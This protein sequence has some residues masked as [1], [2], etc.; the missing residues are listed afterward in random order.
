MWVG[1]V[2]RRGRRKVELVYFATFFV[3]ISRVKRCKARSVLG[4]I[5]L[6]R[7]VLLL[8][9]LYPLSKRNRLI[10]ARNFICVVVETVYDLE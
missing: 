3:Q 7:A 8:C 2:N 4:L 6:A 5:G 9:R 1:L 10:H